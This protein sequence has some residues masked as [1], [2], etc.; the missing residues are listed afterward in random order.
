[1]KARKEI[2][3]SIRDCNLLSAYQE[4]PSINTSSYNIK[5]HCQTTGG[6]ARV[7]QVSEDGLNCLAQKPL[8]SKIK[9]QIVDF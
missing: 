1:M 2:E 9:F 5:P 4:N 8:G 7:L 3:N 6:Y